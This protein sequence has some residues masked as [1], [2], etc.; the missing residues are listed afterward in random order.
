[1][2]EARVGDEVRF[3]IRLYRQETAAAPDPE[4]SDWCYEELTRFGNKRAEPDVLD[5]SL[6]TALKENGFYYFTVSAVGDGTQYV[7]SP[8]VVSNVFEYTGEDAPPLPTPEGLAW[9]LVEDNGE[10]YYYATWSNLDDY[11]DNDFVNVT[12][13]DQDG[14][15][16]MNNTW[17][18]NQILDYGY[19]GIFIRPQFLEYKPGSKYRFTV[20]VYSSRPNEYGSSPMPDPVPEEY[21]SPWLE[22]GPTEKTENESTAPQ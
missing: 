20:Q 12:Y 9:R 22:F 15:Y 17:Q 21:Y 14:T 4:S 18:M 6:V 2:P 11:E 5:W 7:D 8:Y 13:Y 1:M 10:R 19:G 3:L 16:V